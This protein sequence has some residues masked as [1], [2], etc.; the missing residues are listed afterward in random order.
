M[1]I[2]RLFK[3]ANTGLDTVNK[4]IQGHRDR[5]KAR[6][7]SLDKQAFNVGDRVEYAPDTYVSED[8]VPVGSKGTVQD[9]EYAETTGE[10]T[11]LAVEWDDGR[12]ID[13]HQIYLKKA[14]VKQAQSSD[15]DWNTLLMQLNQQ[16]GY[17]AVVPGL[18]WVEIGD[19]PDVVEHHFEDDDG[20][21]VYEEVRQ[22]DEV[23]PELVRLTA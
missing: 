9:I 20:N 8:P 7:D 5:F 16:G 17:A 11:Y 18:N 14:S 13:V 10:A 21:D 22:G 12:W 1:P 23:V 4:A 15:E 2:Q 19:T 3:R 6:W